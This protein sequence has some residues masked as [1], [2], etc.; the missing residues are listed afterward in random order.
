[1]GHLVD[2]CTELIFTNIPSKRICN[3][4]PSEQLQAVGVLK[5]FIILC[6]IFEYIMGITVFM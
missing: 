5:N 2:K 3:H 6:F 1:M 4:F